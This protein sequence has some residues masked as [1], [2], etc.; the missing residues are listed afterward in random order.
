MQ[1]HFFRLLKAPQ[2]TLSVPSLVLYCSTDENIPILVPMFQ[3]YHLRQFI[4]AYGIG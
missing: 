2:A 3:P 4:H 1:Q